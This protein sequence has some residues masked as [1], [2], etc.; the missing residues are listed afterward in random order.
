MSTVKVLAGDI[1]TGDWVVR[2]DFRMTRGAFGIGDEIH[3]KKD[4]Q[5]VEVLTEE[6]KKKFVG[7]AIAG[8]AGALLLGPLG[9]VAGV[10]AGGKSK[11][12]SFICFLKNG[13]KFM[14]TTDNKTYLAI[15]AAIF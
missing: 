2:G 10:L 15:Q 1:H 14:A 5:N 4:I 8:A 12:V 11:Q 13:K 9:L 7:T 6:N 3:F